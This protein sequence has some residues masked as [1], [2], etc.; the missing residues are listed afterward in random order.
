[1][2]AFKWGSSCDLIPGVYIIFP[3]ASEFLDNAVIGVD[4]CDGVGQLFSSMV[5]DIA[6]VNA[7]DIGLPDQVSGPII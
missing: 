3:K 7:V 6:I 4:G 2:R 5:M 1:M